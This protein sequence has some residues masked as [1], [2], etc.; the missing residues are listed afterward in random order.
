MSSNSRGGSVLLA[1]DQ[2]IDV[3][4]LSSPTDLEV[5][6]VRL[7]L[8]MPV[9]ICAVYSPPSPVFS[10]FSHLLVYL[11]TLFSSH[12]P[13]LVVGDFNCPDIDWPTFSGVSPASSAL[14]DF[15]FDFKLLSPR[16]TPR[17]TFLT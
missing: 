8:S 3:T 5:L 9:V 1:V 7:N 11:G 14:C 12:E 13:V 2:S 15:V 10:T 17:V 16:L 4:L 6:A